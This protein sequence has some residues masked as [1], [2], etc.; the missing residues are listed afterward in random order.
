LSFFKNSVL[1]LEI[2]FSMEASI[3]FSRS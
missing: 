1:K 2:T 3:L